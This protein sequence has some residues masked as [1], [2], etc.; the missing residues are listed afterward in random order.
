MT[1][2]LGPDEYWQYYVFLTASTNAESYAWAS[3]DFKAYLTATNIAY[4]SNYGGWTNVKRTC[5]F[6]IAFPNI[7]LTK[8]II[9][10]TN[11]VYNNNSIMPGSVITY[12]IFFS[13]SGTSPGRDL[14]I[15]DILPLP[16]TNY[17]MLSNDFTLSDFATNFK[18][19]GGIEF[20]SDDGVSWDDPPILPGWYGQVDQILFSSPNIIPV[21]GTGLIEY[22]VKIK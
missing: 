16:N 13:N 4:Y 19:L 1:N 20:S 3:V 11:P 5:K 7:Y 2:D 17:L 18:I 8:N 21:G 9:T 14:T 12:Q 10:V 22:K 15:I 6:K